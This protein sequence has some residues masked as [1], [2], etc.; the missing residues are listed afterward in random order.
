MNHN[1]YIGI[2]DTD[3]LVSIGTGHLARDLANSLDDAGLVRIFSITRHQLLVDPKIPFTSHNSAACITGQIT[4]NEFQ[5]REFC[6]DFLLN[7]AAD[8]SDVGLCIVLEESIPEEIVSFGQRA[9]IEVLKEN[10]AL[11]IAKKYSIYLIGLTGQKIGVIGAL[12]AV[13]LRFHGNDG[14]LLWLNRLREIQGIFTI[15]KYQELVPVDTIVDIDGNLLHPE[16][17]INISDWCRPVVKNKKIVLFAEKSDAH[18]KYE[19]QSASKEY[20][21]HLS[22]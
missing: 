15:G 9:K 17:K 21:K 13:G 1:I 19:Y 7:H 3:N 16:S 20:I 4:G 22:E 6:A 18:E 14:R 2:D 12:A 11:D 5:V 8:G 10:E